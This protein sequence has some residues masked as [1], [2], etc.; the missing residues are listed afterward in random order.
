MRKSNITLIF[1]G[2][3]LFQI[4]S[5]SAGCLDEL[6]GS[7]VGWATVANN[8]DPLLP[9]MEVE[10]V[11]DITDIEEARV[12]GRLFVGSVQFLGMSGPPTPFDLTGIFFGRLMKASTAGTVVSAIVKGDGSTMT[13]YYLDT[14]LIPDTRAH[15]QTGKF[16]LEKTTE[17]TD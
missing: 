14:L 2:L 17:E 3:F 11:I 13:G 10:M 8:D 1:A 4:S 12:G 7:W 9:F 5:A 6:C 15:P 16:V